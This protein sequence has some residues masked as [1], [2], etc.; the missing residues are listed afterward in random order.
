MRLYDTW[1]FYLLER[2]PFMHISLVGSI[3]G[4]DDGNDFS[5]HNE[6]L[7]N[8]KLTRYDDEKNI[9]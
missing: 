6:F 7:V 1:V 2:I 4:I 8:D 9:L 3:K 5:H